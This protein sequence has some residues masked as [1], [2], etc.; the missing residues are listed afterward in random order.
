ML[1]AQ[2]VA[3]R[4]NYRNNDELLF[5]FGYAHAKTGIKIQTVD[6]LDSE[7]FLQIIDIFDIYFAILKIPATIL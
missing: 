6:I 5:F 1:F 3:R 4:V 2:F 7:E